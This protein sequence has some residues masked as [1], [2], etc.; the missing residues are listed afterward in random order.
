MLN[1]SLLYGLLAIVGGIIGFIKAGSEVS[2]IA[3]LLSGAAIITSTLAYMRGQMLGYW[4][5]MLLSIM[6]GG[7]FLNGFM[8]TGKIMPQLVM[9]LMSA[10]NLAILLT[11]KRPSQHTALR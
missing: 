3:G 10:A 5:L 1:F 11:V 8:A 2:L 4:V 9:T 6:L 7:W